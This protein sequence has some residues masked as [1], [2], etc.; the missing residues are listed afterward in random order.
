MSSDCC[1]H[2]CQQ[3]DLCPL[4]GACP[5]KSATPLITDNSQG[6]SASNPI[7]ELDD[8]T[9]FLI[10]RGVALTMFAVSVVM[11]LLL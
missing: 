8:D 7:D 10:C 3:G 4:R 1:N 11:Y 9:G 2:D 6:S 5:A